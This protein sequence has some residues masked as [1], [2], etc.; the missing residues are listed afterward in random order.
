ML[1]P[2]WVFS[3]HKALAR[4]GISA[5]DATQFMRLSQSMNASMAAVS[6]GIFYS[7]LSFA[8]GQRAAMVGT[9]MLGLSTANLLHATNSAE[10][11]PGFFFSVVAMAILIVGLSRREKL[12]LALSGGVFA[13]AL[14]SYEASGLAGG[15]AIFAPLLWP[16]GGQMWPAELRTR[17]KWL[18]YIAFGGIVGVC[19][20]YGAAYHMQ[21]IGV[22]DM[23]R[24][25]FDAGGGGEAY[26]Y[27]RLSKM[28]NIPFGLIANLF[29]GVPPGY[30]GVR[31]LLRNDH[32]NLWIPL[33]LLGLV[34]TLTM[35]SI[36]IAG[37]L[38]LT[39]RL[40]R[41]WLVICLLPLFA[42]LFPLLYWDPMYDKLWF[43]PLAV[44]AFL[45][46][47]SL[48]RNALRGALRRVQWSLVIVVI[49]TEAIVN[50]PRVVHQHFAE[51]PHLQDAK[52]LASIAGPRDWIV[53][54]FDD[55]SQLWIAFWGY[56]SKFLMLPASSRQQTAKWFLD[57]ESSCRTDKSR[58]LF[59]NVLDQDR[60]TW[61]E[62][63]GKR[64]GI[65]FE[66]LEKYRREAVVI[67]AFKSADHPSTVRAVACE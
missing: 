64:I 5:T 13:L 43:T 18:E 37:C 25:F 34:L 10:V 22:S 8:T 30:S 12:L 58:I 35:V 33:V 65:P 6:L 42:V 4:F 39:G 15:L 23:P 62:F 61:T 55:I 29:G 47:L 59:V 50:V 28:V 66:M 27:F 56:G 24:R 52:S 53:L 14:A 26:G 45:T 2:A 17:L 7:L 44:I 21:G 63:L 60:D 31:S 40:Q 49:A 46:A 57:A 11:L 48:K 3:W 1:Y 36:S 41:S 9:L 38:R 32:R 51:T 19:L 16:V 20:I 67:S 54:D